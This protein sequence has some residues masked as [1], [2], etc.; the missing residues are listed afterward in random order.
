M[1]I[2]YLIFAE[3]YANDFT[4][5]SEANLFPSPRWDQ[6]VT[7]LCAGQTLQFS[8]NQPTTVMVD[9]SFSFGYVF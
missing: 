9:N 5:K 4:W 1:V 8:P 7:Q 6:N 3:I 2:F